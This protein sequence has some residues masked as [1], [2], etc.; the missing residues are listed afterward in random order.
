[1]SAKIT[2]TAIF[3]TDGCGDGDL[4]M[5]ITFCHCGQAK[6]EDSE[7]LAALWQCNS[8]GLSLVVVKRY[9]NIP[10]SPEGPLSTSI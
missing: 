7:A 9:V 2:P 8:L 1:M 3:I 4:G 10:F 6:M 5:V